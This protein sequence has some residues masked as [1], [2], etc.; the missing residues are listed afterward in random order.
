ME[1][2]VYR[3]IFDGIVGMTDYMPCLNEREID[4]LR[5]TVVKRLKE[6][7]DG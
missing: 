6:E 3:L 2:D 1:T 4:A 5:S 7:D